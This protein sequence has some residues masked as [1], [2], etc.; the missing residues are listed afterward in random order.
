MY[1]GKASP[2]DAHVIVSEPPRVVESAEAEIAKFV[3]LTV[4]GTWLLP[5]DRMALS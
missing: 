3:G 5:V 1:N 2:V 4:M